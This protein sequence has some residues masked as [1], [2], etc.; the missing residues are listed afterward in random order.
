MRHY[1]AKS[2]FIP[3]RFLLVPTGGGAL[4]VMHAAQCVG[5]LWPEGTKWW[6]RDDT[7]T[8]LDG[9]TNNDVHGVLSALFA[10]RREHVFLKAL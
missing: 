4:Q 5:Y 8:L 10:A 7:G 3:E 2:K 9:G 6:A 1:Q